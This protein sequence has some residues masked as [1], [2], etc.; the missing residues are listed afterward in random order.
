MVLKKFWGIIFIWIMK[1]ETFIRLSSALHG[2][3]PVIEHTGWTIPPRMPPTAH[4]EH[5]PHMKGR[6]G[7]EISPYVMGSNVPMEAI[8]RR[9]WMFRNGDEEESALAESSNQA[10]RRGRHRWSCRTGVC[11]VPPQKHISPV[12]LSAAPC[13]IPLSFSLATSCLFGNF[14]FLI[15]SYFLIEK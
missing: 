10:G 1:I 5:S 6:E 14:I 12:P 11:I 9:E 15:D 7:R 2:K 8:G 4:H 3:C 13:E